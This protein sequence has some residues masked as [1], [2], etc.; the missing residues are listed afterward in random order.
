MSISAAPSAIYMICDS[1]K[2]KHEQN[3]VL[4][5][6]FSLHGRA[7]QLLAGDQVSQILLLTVVAMSNL[8]HFANSH[9]DKKNLHLGASSMTPQAIASPSW[10]EIN[11]SPGK[12]PF[13]QNNQLNAATARIKQNTKSACHQ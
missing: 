1:L 6:K 4:A 12:H 11:H 8:H 9:S 2:I 7:S 5:H 3:L 13:E 10:G